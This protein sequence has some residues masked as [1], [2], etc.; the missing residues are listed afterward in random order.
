M[1][2]TLW[3]KHFAII[4]QMEVSFKDGMTVLTG[5]TGAGKSLII[6]AIG[7]LLGDRAN[8][9]MIRTGEN[10]ATVYGVFS[11]ESDRLQAALEQQ[12][13]PT[14]DQELKI[15]REITL[16]N[17]NTIKI[18]DVSV[19]LQQLKEITRHLAD[20]HSQFDTQRLLSP[21]YYLDLIDGF[22]PDVLLPY[23]EKYQ[24]ELQNY[25]EKHKAYTEFLAMQKELSDKMDIYQFQLKE[26][27]ALNLIEN[28]EETLEKEASVLANFD[29]INIAL[30]LAIEAFDQ[31]L[32]DKLYSL[33]T[34]LETLS[35]SGMDLAI[36]TTKVKD[37]YYE[38]EDIEKTL[39][40][41]L[42]DLAF[43]PDE[44]NR[45]NDRINDL[46]KVK[47]KYKKTVAELIEYQKMIA[48]VI[49]KSENYDEYLAKQKNALIEAHNRVVQ[50]SGSITKI[51]REIAKQVE[52]ELMTV[53]QDLVLKNTIF[54]IEF[55]ANDTTDYLK[56][57]GFTATGVDQVDFLI[58][59]N[60]GETLKPLAKTASG[61][62]MS[63]IMLAFKTIFIK[64]QNLSTM[65]FDE[66]DTGI[67]GVVAKQIAK[68]LRSISNSTQVL[69]ISH[70]PQVVAMAK[71]QLRVSKQEV[72]KRTIA[73][74]KELS[75]DERVH[76]IAEMISGDHLSV[77]GIEGAK[78]L[79][80]N[81]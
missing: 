55:K 16:A 70:V 39:K 12:K 46:D 31:G 27:S 54:Q 58:S 76:D 20:I 75:F 59:T 41:K 67:S 4:D 29:K 73:S 74:I 19:T 2:K 68:K 1:I 35:D 3:V 57:E 17:K 36:E 53:F 5:E 80:L 64:S 69:A 32:S 60:V 48:S 13:I 15:T 37:A 6:D 56:K 66:I 21:Q 11:I 40:R 28:E 10:S 7:L 34:E 23:V 30:N 26:L 14:W 49:D 33:M 42:R 22:R 61:G 9:E 38:F 51:R 24:I 25:L 65:I 43:D 78:E 50:A 72:N 81:P 44:L 79:L 63:R 18:N 47:K 8:S 77:N 52:K 62:E 45:I 71:Y